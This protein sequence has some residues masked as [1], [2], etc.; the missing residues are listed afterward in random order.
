[1]P[2]FDWE[3]SVSLSPLGGRLIPPT[4]T[5][6]VTKE[7]QIPKTDQISNIA[8]YCHYDPMCSRYYVP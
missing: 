2:A 3:K 1:M 4:L 5:P 7:P 8:C 6:M